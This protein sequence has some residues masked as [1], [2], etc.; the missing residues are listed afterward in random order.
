MTVYS[1]E[2]QD[3]WTVQRFY[4]GN[5][6]WPSDVTWRYRG[7]VYQTQVYMGFPTKLDA[8]RWVREHRKQYGR[9][10][11]H[12]VVIYKDLD[13]DNEQQLWRAVYWYQ[14]EDGEAMRMYL[15]H[16]RAAWR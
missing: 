5:A 11:I 8:Q 9:E 12:D 6:I 13:T 16:A 7:V 10:W 4:F 2:G 3:G 15:N 14:P 1:Y